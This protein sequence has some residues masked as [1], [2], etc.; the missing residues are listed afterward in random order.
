M[1]V[2]PGAVVI[3]IQKTQ[4]NNTQVEAP[5]EC[6]VMQVKWYQYDLKKNDMLRA[7]NFYIVRATTLF[8]EESS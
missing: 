6:I 7:S 5:A 1:C 2:S 3:G 4:D 8:P